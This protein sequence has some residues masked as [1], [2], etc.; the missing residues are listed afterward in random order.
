MIG[1]NDFFNGLIKI[2][3]SSLK[4]GYHFTLSGDSVMKIVLNRSVGTQFSISS[5][6]VGRLCELKGLALTK[7]ISNYGRPSQE[8]NL[9]YS[10]PRNDKDL[11]QVVEELGMGASDY[12]AELTVVEIPDNV[13][14]SI[15]DIF[16]YEY[17]MAA[18]EQYI[19]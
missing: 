14:W 11:V 3:E 18:G 2:K 10:L 7:L 6:A 17:V 1:F 19:P 5:S 9:L 4:G 16:G 13:R 12:D 15:S 8:T